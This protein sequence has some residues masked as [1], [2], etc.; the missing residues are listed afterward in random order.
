MSNN[1]GYSGGAEEYE[2]PAADSQWGQYDESYYNSDG[3]QQGTDYYGNAES[4]DYYGDYTQ[5]H[6]QYGDYSNTDASGTQ[7]DAGGSNQYQYDEYDPTAYDYGAQQLGSQYDDNSFPT[8]SQ[9]EV[10][11]DASYSDPTSTALPSLDTSSAIADSNATASNA[12]SAF[13]NAAAYATPRPKTPPP[14][15]REKEMTKRVYDRVNKRR[16]GGI[17]ATAGMKQLRNEVLE[18]EKR[19]ST[20]HDI[21]KSKQTVALKKSID[22]SRFAVVDQQHASELLMRSVETQQDIASRFKVN[23]DIARQDLLKQLPTLSSVQER[24]HRLRTLY[25]REAAKASEAAKKFQN[26]G[27]AIVHQPPVAKPVVAAR[28]RVKEEL[29]ALAPMPVNE[30]FKHLKTADALE[31]MLRDKRRETTS[32][33]SAA[34]TIKTAGLGPRP[35]TVGDDQDEHKEVDLNDPYEINR[36]LYETKLADLLKEKSRSEA[37]ESGIDPDTGCIPPQCP[38]NVRATAVSASTIQLTWDPPIF[39]GGQPIMDYVVYFVPCT[40]E[41]IG[42]RTKRTFGAEEHFFTTRWYKPNP[43]AHNGFTWTFRRAETTFA[44]VYV[45]AVNVVGQGSASNV[46]QEVTM[47]FAD[48]PSRPTNVCVDK[49]TTRSIYLRWQ[50][51]L[52]DGGA[53]IIRYHIT[54]TYQTWRDIKGPLKG[55][56]GGRITATAHI[57][58]EDPNCHRYKVRFVRVDHYLTPGINTVVVHLMFCCRSQISQA[59]R[60]TIIYVCKQRTLT[61][62]YPSGQ[63]PLKVFALSN[64][65]TCKHVRTKSNASVHSSMSTVTQT[66]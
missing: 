19:T 6:Q 31:Q 4:G 18:Y 7:G 8:Y 41:K 61:A 48:N 9:G 1:D 22:A 10:N 49:V 42:K 3:Y 20:D 58:V 5:Q 30:M 14:H 66:C 50:P 12:V 27:R 17:L 29:K 16:I 57:E 13:G 21:L 23:Q 28:L 63:H 53:P 15:W 38:L 33:A 55:G 60:N 52:D 26:R 43:I 64:A 35:K 34:V 32:A 40:L 46:V 39:D 11:D 2:Q 36:L 62:E 56:A 59:T 47:P 37:L 44:R 54:Y 65:M 25:T 24:V 45:R 51:P